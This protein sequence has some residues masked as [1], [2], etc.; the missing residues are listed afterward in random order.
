[1]PCVVIYS[2]VVTR[3]SISSTSGI[4][5]DD[6]YFQMTAAIQP[7]NSGGPVVNEFGAVVGVV[8][9]KLDALK[10]A[11]VTGDIPQNI[12]FAIR[13]EL[14]KL[15]LTKHSVDFKIATNRV[16]VEPSALADDAKRYAV[17]I[18]C[19]DG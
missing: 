1:M 17:V 18:S 11:A 9:S 12:N 14:A 2:V 8:V 10:V 16:R 19:W 13:A 5:G 3:G 4:R 15:F 7:G 6:D